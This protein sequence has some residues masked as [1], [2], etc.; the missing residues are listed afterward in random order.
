MTTPV[1]I[2]RL[3]TGGG[4]CLRLPRC[5]KSVLSIF[6]SATSVGVGGASDLPIDGDRR[7]FCI[8][9]A[10]DID[11]GGCGLIVDGDRGTSSW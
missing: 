11:R 3:L 4:D 7:C 5:A 8:Y 2:R 6:E 9:E 1:G 10:D